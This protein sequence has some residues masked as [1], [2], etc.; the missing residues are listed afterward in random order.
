[1]AFEKRA[2]N[3][4]YI[5]PVGGFVVVHVAA[6]PTTDLTRIIFAVCKVDGEVIG[7]TSAADNRLQGVISSTSQTMTI[8]VHANSI[9]RVEK[10][11]DGDIDIRWIAI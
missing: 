9:Y 5:A 7:Q 4:D 3:T 10:T 11:G 8:P 6:K 1:M 2:L